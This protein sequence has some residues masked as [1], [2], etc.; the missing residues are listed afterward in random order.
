MLAIIF[1]K[2]KKKSKAANTFQDE[3]GFRFSLVS[4]QKCLI[5][6]NWLAEP[7]FKKT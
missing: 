7:L 3:S 5:C 6:R 2:T 1:D 4:F